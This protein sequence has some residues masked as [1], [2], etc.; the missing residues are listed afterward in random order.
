[1]ISGD[2]VLCIN[3]KNWYEIPVRGI[4]EGLIYTLS[5]VF[6]C[7][8]GNIYVRL[9]E[10]PDYLNMWCPTCNTTEFTRMYFHIERFRKI[11]EEENSQKD[12]I[13]ESAGKKVASRAISPN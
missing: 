12:T 13:E 6:E 9:S 7:R 1:M 5:E 11:D 8:C 4:C 2:K 3:D 10:V